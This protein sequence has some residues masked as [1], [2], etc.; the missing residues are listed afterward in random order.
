MKKLD[1]IHCAKYLQEGRR[2]EGGWQ[3]GGRR[4][5]GRREEGGGMQGGGMQEEVN[6]FNIML[7]L[8]REWRWAHSLLPS[9]YTTLTEYK[10]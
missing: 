1:F 4:E 2:E 8:Q 6:T 10:K 5:A 3:G 9:N 7:A